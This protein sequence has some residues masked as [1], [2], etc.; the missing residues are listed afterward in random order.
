MDILRSPVASDF[1]SRLWK[2]VDQKLPVPFP[3]S[4]ADFASPNY[5]P[6]NDSFGAEVLGD[7]RQFSM[8]R[9]YHD[10]GYPQAAEMTTDSRLIGRSVWNTEWML[11]IPGATLLNDKDRGLDVFIHQVKDIKLLFQTYSYSG[12]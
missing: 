4:A 12:N 3:L 6:I 8:F 10:S 7:I 1:R 9:A 5:L 11:I 2:V